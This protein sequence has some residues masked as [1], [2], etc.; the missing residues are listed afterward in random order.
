[1]SL[2]TC[3]ASAVKEGTSP[4][5][6]ETGAVLRWALVLRQG[7]EWVDGMFWDGLGSYGA[8]GSF[9]RRGDELDAKGVPTV[10]R[11]AWHELAAQGHELAV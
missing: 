6:D 9:Y 7:W 8:R 3:L 10:V 11:A 5:V 2:G 4:G 1:M